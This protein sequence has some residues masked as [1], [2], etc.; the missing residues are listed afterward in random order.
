MSYF[1]GVTASE[2]GDAL[3]KFSRR[4]NRQATELVEA[5]EFAV[6]GNELTGV[7]ARERDS[8]WIACY[9]ILSLSGPLP[10]T[11][12]DALCCLGRSAVACACLQRL[13]LSRGWRL[14]GRGWAAAHPAA[15]SPARHAERELSSSASV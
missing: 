15:A 13:L 9:S 12:A 8:L 10:P 6:M 1:D 4:L 5:Q 3:R 11:A 2:H 14:R 7:S